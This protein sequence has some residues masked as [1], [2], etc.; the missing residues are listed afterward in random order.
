M[1]IFC[2]SFRE[3]ALIFLHA[4]QIAAWLR[5]ERVS[6]HVKSA[7]FPCLS[8]GYTVGMVELCDFARA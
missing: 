2:M 1:C 7:H 4:I 5:F 8:L 6:L 3:L